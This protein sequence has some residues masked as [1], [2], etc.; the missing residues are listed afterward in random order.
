MM[1]FTPPTSPE[2]L[3]RLLAII[4]GEVTLADKSRMNRE[5]HVRFSEGVGVKFP[6]A[7]RLNL[8]FLNVRKL[9]VWE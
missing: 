4:D 9:T 2:T 8:L 3:K 5:V 7:T 6:R 1:D